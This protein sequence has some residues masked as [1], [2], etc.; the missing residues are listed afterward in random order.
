MG[1]F[2][3][4]YALKCI[5]YWIFVSN[6]LFIELS[7]QN[8]ENTDSIQFK[9]IDQII[10]LIKTSTKEKAALYENALKSKK[11]PNQKLAEIYIDIGYSFYRKEESEISIS[12]FQKAIDLAKI[13]NDNETLSNAYLK[14]GNSYLQDWQNQK[15]LDTYHKV[16]QM[17]QKRGNLKKEIV[18]KSNIA[19]VLRRMNQLDRALEDCR[20]LLNFIDK[21]SFKNGKN[22]VNVLTIISEVYLDLEQFDSVLKYADIGTAISTPL[23]YKIGIADLYTK[24]GI[25]FYE[26]KDYD[27][28]LNFLYQAETILNELKISDRSNQRINVNYFL[29]SYFYD[30]RS[31]EKT[32]DYLLKTING[33]KENDLR[34]NRVI[35]AH[36]L[37]AKSYKEIGDGEASIIWFSKHQEL[38]D[39]FQKD[40]DKTVHKIHDQNTQQLDDKIKK[41]ETRQVTEQKYK[42]YILIALSVV[43]ILFIAILITYF[44]KQKANKKLF[45]RLI[46]KISDLEAKDT[47]EII[48]TKESVKEITIDDEKINAVLKGLDK[49]EKQE[50][51]LSVDCNLRSIAKKVK[52]NATYLSRI[53]NNY[54]GKSFNDYINDLRID[55]VLKRL[56]NDNKFRSFS[57]SSIATEIGYKSDNSFTKHFKAKTGLN[58]SYYIKNIEKL[59]VKS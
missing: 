13:N 21:T 3:K 17:A 26:R 33:L 32:I 34:K 44:K 25:V 18:V 40:K 47:K 30:I 15:A 23:N 28:A 20:N 49:L 1:F 59:S 57:I 48:E 56:K 52:T 14:L 50:Y 58:P 39:Q 16:L 7:A 27:Q 2:V 19:I 38:Q 11:L 9:S 53:I 31:Y 4:R 45:N 29:A 35:D 42:S 22:H 55:Y 24:K 12:Y 5:F 36:M 37:L 41:L 51:F 10:D 43:F 8:I 46:Q 54:K 6:F